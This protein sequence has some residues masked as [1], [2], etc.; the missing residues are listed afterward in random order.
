MNKL[1]LKILSLLLVVIA[2][3][4]IFDLSKYLPPDLIFHR[5]IKFES[6][7]AQ[8]RLTQEIKKQGIPHRVRNDGTIE[9]R[10]KNSKKVEQIRDMVN[11]SMHEESE[12]KQSPPNIHFSEIEKQNLL[13]NLLDKKGIPYRIERFD[14][15]KNDYVVWETQYNKEIEK[16][17]NN[18]YEQYDE[19]KPS[20][21]S[22]PTEEQNKYFISL[23]EKEGILYKIEE[24]EENGKKK[25]YIK[26]K[27]KNDYKIRNLQIQTLK[28]NP[29]N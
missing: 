3:W 2:A 23:L 26:Y 14:K 8:D 6:K 17:I 7:D 4:F 12:E 29:I 22:F 24:K 21:I 10:E 28:E 19:E 18:I 5:G 11:Y 20:S 16:I 9:Y 1:S 13:I 27:S 15:E 25:R